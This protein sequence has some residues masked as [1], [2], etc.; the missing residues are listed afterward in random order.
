MKDFY[1]ILMV[2]SIHFRRE[3][4]EIIDKF[5]HINPKLGILNFD[6]LKDIQR[7]IY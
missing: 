3:I 5:E 1:L 2:Q 4:T 7:I 6:L